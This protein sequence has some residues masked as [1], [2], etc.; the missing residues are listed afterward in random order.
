M[1][2]AIALAMVLVGGCGIAVY[3]AGALPE[4]MFVQDQLRQ[5]GDHDGRNEGHE[6]IIRM[7]GYVEPVSEVRRLSFKIDGV[8]ANC[9]VE[10]GQ[11]VQVGDVLATLRNQD[12][13][14]R[15]FVAERELA[16]ARAE[17]DKLFSGVH[18]KQIEAAECRL[19]GL[20]ERVRHLRQQYDRQ[21]ALRE[22]NSISVSEFDLAS[23]ELRQAEE[24]LKAVSADLIELQTRVR[25]EDRAL[26]ESKVELAEANVVA[27]K[28]RLQDT[29][30]TAP[31]GGTI[32]E[33]LKREG[34]ALRV[35]DPYPAI[36]LADLSRLRVRAEL[37][38][39]FVDR[40]HVGQT[41]VVYG[42]GLNGRRVT[43]TV[44]F[45]KSLMGN[46]TVFSRESSERKDLDVLQVF[47]ETG[48]PLLAPVGLQVDVDLLSKK[49]AL[50]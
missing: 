34:E 43:G 35:F 2:S 41:A 46:K 24:E 7:I 5:A 36:V 26:A 8:V 49:G 15:V 19:L 17:R 10:V 31:I 21:K 32:L 27:A 20:E 18:P 44:T 1:K 37:D 14:A 33:V 39:H 29:I 47:V 28:E 11:E 38:E 22:K 42:S 3:L 4:Q 50:E 12:E 6:R 9:K 40:V 48:T 13:Q 30:M 23:T 25:V 45:V 16:V